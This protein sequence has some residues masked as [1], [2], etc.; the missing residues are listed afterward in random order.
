MN[1]NVH[2]TSYEL[3]RDTLRAGLAVAAG[4]GREGG[5][6][7]TPC[8]TIAALYTL[9]GDHQVDQHGHC[10]RCRGLRALPGRRRRICRVLV[11]ARFYLYQPEDILLRL[12]A[13]ELHQ[14]ATPRLIAEAA[15]EPD[16]V[17]GAILGDPD[18]T[19]VLSRIG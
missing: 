10:R 4:S 11:A 1:R 18:A 15:P 8:R 13:S 3:L 9:L 16:R 7:S 17:P 19:D 2:Q 14:H 12:L 6:G 5:I